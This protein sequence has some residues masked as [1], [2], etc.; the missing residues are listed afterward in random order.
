MRRSRSTSRPSCAR[1]FARR[2]HSGPARAGGP[3]SR[4]ISSRRPGPRDIP[5]SSTRPSTT[6][7]ERARS[8]RRPNA[9][10]A[11]RLRW[12]GGAR[13]RAGRVGSGPRHGR[14]DSGAGRASRSSRRKVRVGSGSGWRWPRR[15]PPAIAGQL[16]LESAPGHGTTVRLRLPTAAR[17]RSGSPR[18]DPVAP[19]D[20]PAS[21][22]LRTKSRFGRRSSRPSSATATR[23]RAAG[24]VGDAVALL[25]R[26]T[27]DIVVTDLVLPG[28][29]GSRDRPYGQ[30]STARHSG[31]PGHAAGPGG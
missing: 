20:A 3:P 30:A 1:R 23:C 17:P 4:S 11:I 8:G 6:S 14:G 7:E 12:D 25:G 31:D 18:P 21:S 9:P 29:S 24:D 13:R 16:D 27:V 22:W 19:A 5:T 28:G 15:W 26:E 2:S 10:I